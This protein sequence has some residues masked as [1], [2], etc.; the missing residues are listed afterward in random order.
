MSNNGRE[1]D[2]VGNKNSERFEESSGV[3]RGSDLAPMLFL[4]SIDDLVRT[5]KLP[6]FM[7][8]DDVK[9]MVASSREG[10]A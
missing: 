5:L 8:M 2:Q 6:C 9:V 10:L 7:V 3:P 4:P 1:T